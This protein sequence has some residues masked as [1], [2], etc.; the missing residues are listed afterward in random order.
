MPQ[1]FATSSMMS[2][3]VVVRSA[4]VQGFEKKDKKRARSEKRSKEKARKKMHKYGI[5]EKKG[6]TPNSV[7]PREKTLCC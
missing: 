7:I 1:V 6:N 3:A 2:I 4:A 5:I